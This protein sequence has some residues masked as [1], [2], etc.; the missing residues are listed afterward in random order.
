MSQFNTDEQ[1]D[2]YVDALK[3]EL[4]GVMQRDPAGPRVKAIKAELTR[5]SA[6]PKP[7]RRGVG[8]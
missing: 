6:E 1:R 8:E 2:R 3:E 7:K 5:V 4:A